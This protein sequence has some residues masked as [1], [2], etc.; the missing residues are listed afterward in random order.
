MT[1]I[2][3]FRG[4]RY[5]PEEA[6]A[7]HSLVAPP[8]D[9]IDKQ[10]QRLLYAKSPYNIIRLEYGETR[11]GDDTAVNRYTRAAT[12]FH[13][14]LAENILTREAG[15]TLYFYEQ[16]FSSQEQRHTRCGLIA[17]VGLEDYATGTILPHE[18]TLAKAKTDR[19][20][21]LRATGANFSPIFG[22]YD[23]PTGTV[24]KV[25]ARYKHQAPQLHFTDDS[26]EVHRLWIVGDDNDLAALCHFFLDQ[27]IYIADGHHRY[28]TA[29]HFHQEML[30]C[31]QD[32]FAFVLMTLVNLHDPGLVVLP[33]HRLVKDV[34]A[35]DRQD[36]LGQLSLLFQV[37]PLALTALHGT[38]AAVSELKKMPD[39]RATAHTF[40]L[41]LGDGNLYLLS[42]S[43]DLA[44]REMSSRAGSFSV[45]WRSLDVAV[46][47]CLI[48]EGVLGIGSE[49]RRS[50]QNL[51]YTRSEAEALSLVDS[52]TYQAAFFLHPTLVGEVTAVASVGDKMPQKSTY[53]YPKLLTG[54]VINDFVFK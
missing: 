25:A 32:S 13:R 20:E 6:G 23:D 10:A 8:Y 49:A 15:P 24:E 33:T 31:G 52:G 48:L 50:G 17:G 16:E 11:L 7:M 46:L 45:A 26:G 2:I 22:L 37:T 9:V 30:A 19:L 14:W 41:Y 5:N 4:L 39:A 29:L 18:E 38:E 51:S 21:L 12:L 27:K 1:K 44:A 53:F 42:L 3:P 54:L 43:R 36:L 40:A 34:S 28:E 35:F 47:Q